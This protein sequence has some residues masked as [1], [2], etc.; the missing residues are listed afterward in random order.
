MTNFHSICLQFFPFCLADIPTTVVVAYYW[1]YM[2]NMWRLEWK[3]VLYLKSSLWLQCCHLFTC[4]V[5]TR[6][7]MQLW[8]DQPYWQLWMSSWMSHWCCPLVTLTAPHCCRL[9]IWLRL[10][11]KPRRKE[12]LN[13]KLS[14]RK[15]WV[16]RFSIYSSLIFSVDVFVFNFPDDILRVCILENLGS[17]NA[18]STPHT[19]CGK[20][21]SVYI[22]ICSLFVN[23]C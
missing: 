3:K 5:S 21:N 13:W 10:N 18:M 9:C 20:T 4:S 16:S 15:N 14:K 8:I 6:P 23:I 2:K 7:C 11:S 17:C 22:R 12:T 19:A 1:L